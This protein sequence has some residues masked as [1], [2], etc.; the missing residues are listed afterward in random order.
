MTAR[1]VLGVVS[2]LLASSAQADTVP[3]RLTEGN[4]RGFLVLRSPQGDV[5]GCGE[6]SLM[7]VGT[8]V[9]WRMTVWLMVGS[10]R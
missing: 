4:A 7:A 3:V 10:L 1:I 8:F 9:D 6:L 2:I 5:V